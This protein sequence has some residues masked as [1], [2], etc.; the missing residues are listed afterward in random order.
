MR[1]KMR[2]LGRILI[3]EGNIIG[4]FF[5]YSANRLKYGIYEIH[6]I[7]DELQLVYIGEPA[8]ENKRVN[9]LDFTSLQDPQVMLTSQELINATEIDSK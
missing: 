5:P 3:R 2:N 6:E 8:L 4:L 1:D 7:L 9:A